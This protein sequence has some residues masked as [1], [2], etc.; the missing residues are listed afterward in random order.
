M[1]Y[2]KKTKEKYSGITFGQFNDMV[3]EGVKTLK[4]KLTK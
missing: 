4:D 3:N 2:A 1:N